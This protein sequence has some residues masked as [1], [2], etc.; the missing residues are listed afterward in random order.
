MG[1]IMLQ[2]GWLTPC[3]VVCG[4]GG[5]RRLP[6]QLRRC[7]LWY[8]SSRAVGS[9]RLM[10]LPAETLLLLPPPSIHMAVLQAGELPTQACLDYLT[11]LTR[12]IVQE[13]QAMDLERRGYDPQ[14]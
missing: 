3:G 1:T 9:A 5:H 2:V 11:Q 12:R 8:F 4:S 13:T 14:V 7:S 10:A 6:L